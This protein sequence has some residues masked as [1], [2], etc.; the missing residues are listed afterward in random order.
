MKTKVRKVLGF[1]QGPCSTFRNY[2]DWAGTLRN[3]NL[4]SE[5]G[6]KYLFFAPARSALPGALTAY[7]L[8]GI[9]IFFVRDKSTGV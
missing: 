1:H 7:Y 5:R 6:T 8:M 9:C 3:W 2:I 4:V